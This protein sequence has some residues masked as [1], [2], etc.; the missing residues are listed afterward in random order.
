MVRAYVL[1][2]QRPYPFG[3]G[4]HR[5]ALALEHEQAFLLGGFDGIGGH[6][7]PGYAA[8]EIE[9]LV[10]GVELTVALQVFFGFFDVAGVDL[11]LHLD[12]GHAFPVDHDDVKFSLLFAFAAGHIGADAVVLDATQYGVGT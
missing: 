6:A 8:I 9:V 11:V 1:T 5:I 12:H 3:I 10:L 2:S 4:R 7:E